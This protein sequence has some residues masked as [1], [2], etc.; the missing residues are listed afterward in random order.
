MLTNKINKMSEN[1]F[2]LLSEMIY[3]R[4]GMHFPDNKKYIL[5]NRLSRRIED[6]GFDNYEKYIE[7]LKYD[8]GKE[9]EFANLFNIITT[10]E[11]FFFRDNNQLQAFETN[12]LPEVVKNLKSRGSKKLRIWSAACSTGEE[13]YT[14]AMI[15]SDALSASEYSDWDIEIHGSDISEAVLSSARRGEYNDYSVRNVMPQQLSKYFTKNGSGKYIIKQEIKQM[16]RF[17]NIN[18]S[19]ESA[20]RMYRGMDIIFCRNVLIYFNE[21]SKK[22]V[23]SGLYNSLISSG[24][25]FIGHSESLFNITRAFKIVSVNG[26]LIYQK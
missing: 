19:D 4:S 18:L 8:A 16:V 20:L 3:A 15:V 17:S 9:R 25:M 21:A 10:N 7:F 12:I 26:I 22:K 6:A 14:L 1:A 23:I 2:H 13:P 5:E 24:Y 11:T